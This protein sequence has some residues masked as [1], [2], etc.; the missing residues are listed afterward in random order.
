MNLVENYIESVARALAATPLVEVSDFPL[1]QPVTAGLALSPPVAVAALVLKAAV[2]L[3]LA[4]VLGLLPP[5]KADQFSLG[6]KLGSGSFGAVYEGYQGNDDTPSAVIKSIDS[7]SANVYNSDVTAKG[8]GFAEL[9]IN[10]KLMFCG[11][12]RCMV[13][14]PSFGCSHAS[15]HAA[16]FHPWAQRLSD[17]AS[18][19]QAQ[20]N[21]HSSAGAFFTL[22][23]WIPCLPLAS[24]LLADIEASPS[25]ADL[26]SP[27]LV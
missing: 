14:P 1:Y 21:P 20:R 4:P 3:L 18:P 27:R 26:V 24:P 10:Q 5:G 15:L 22:L 17:V 7:S 8:F 12:S 25:S 19:Q 16:S 11:Q 13:K 23:S 6:R 9:F 2:E